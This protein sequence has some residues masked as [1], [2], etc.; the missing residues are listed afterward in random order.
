MLKKRDRGKPKQAFI[1]L[2]LTYNR[3]CSNI[4]KGI[5][6]HWSLLAINEFLK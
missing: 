2:T 6:K 5:G 3:F 1:P 4:S